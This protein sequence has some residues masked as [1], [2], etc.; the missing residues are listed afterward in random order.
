MENAKS[1]SEVTAYVKRLLQNDGNLRSVI[2]K[3]E[4]SNCKYHSSGHI[5]FTL[6]DEV[7]GLGSVMF[8]GKRSTGLNFT[9]KDG[10]K[11]FVEGMVSVYERDG[12][13]QLY[14]NTIILDGVGRLYEEF[15][16]LKKKLALEGLFEETHKKE[17]PLFPSRIGIVT[18][19]TGA[20]I[21]DIL[22]T[23][24]RRNPYVQLV[25]YPAKVQ[26]EGAADTIVRGIKRLDSENL[27]II[28]IGRGGG[29]I[30]DLWCF[31]EEAVAR[32]VFAC[33]TPIISAVGHEVD[34]TISDFVADYRAA[35]P[36]AA[37]ELA[38]PEIRSVLDE[39]T[40]IR[41]NF[42]QI[43]RAKLKYLGAVLSHLEVRLMKE[44]PESKIRELAQRI[45][46]AEEGFKAL[47]EKKLLV[48]N[49]KLSKV[50]M[51]LRHRMR[52]EFE[53]VNR[54]F[55]ISVTKLEGL[56]PLTRLTAGYS[57]VE[58]GFG[59]NIRT[60]R[61]IKVDDEIKITLADGKVK[62]R[63]EEIE[64]GGEKEA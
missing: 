26:G 35:T 34:F 5:Y 52:L 59:K 16:R 63:V 7:S 32:A 44:S 25:L 10:Q 53:K 47:M 17:M 62:A 1:V 60:V 64:N 3:G 19:S 13:C 43:L 29:S 4:I 49:T 22:T 18:A 37:A 55:M 54:R 21:H 8:A 12:R 33:K 31:N 11:V 61:N 14:A 40:S 39:L 51:E 57:Y 45:D 9:L 30:E 6:K 56:S 48:L 24:K 41:M 38:V 23:V 36:T 28:I 2:V 20:A 58:D 50:S 15:Q 27:D 42:E 46:E